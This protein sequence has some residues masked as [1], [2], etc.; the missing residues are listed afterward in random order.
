MGRI[1]DADALTDYIV[2][3]NVGCGCYE[4]YQKSFMESIDEQPTIE[5]VRKGKWVDG[6]CSQCGYHAPYWP[7]ATTYYESKYCPYCGAKMEEG[8][9]P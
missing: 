3:H 4:D 2:I 9:Q 5:P 7:M 6:R 1:I 8:E